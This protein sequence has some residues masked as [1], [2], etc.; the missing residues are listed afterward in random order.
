MFRQSACGLAAAALAF[1][2]ASCTTQPSPHLIR[3][4]VPDQKMLVFNQGVEIAR[5][6]V[7]TSKFGVGDRPGSYA[8][9]LGEMVV[10]EK[11]GG[12]QPSGMKFKSRRPT[13]EIVKPNAPG[14]D[15]IVTRILWLKG[16]EA[17]NRRAFDRGIYIHGTAEEWSIGTPASYGCIRMRSRDVLQ[18]FDKVGVG[19]RVEVMNSH[20]PASLVQGSGESAPAQQFNMASKPPVGPSPTAAVPAPAVAPVQTASAAPTPSKSAKPKKRP[21]TPTAPSTGPTPIP[22]S[23]SAS[24][25]DTARPARG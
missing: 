10:K 12:G 25:G 5:Y 23:R 16:L 14:R 8:T 9:P 22:A 7:S 21:S 24:S 19:T 1:G 15:P 6:D 13:G 20:F 4:S 17:Q 11:I 18:L 2:L 3:I